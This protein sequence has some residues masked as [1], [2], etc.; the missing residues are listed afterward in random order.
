[1]LKLLFCLAICLLTTIP[2]TAMARHG[3]DGK[4]VITLRDGQPCF[5]YPRDEEIKKRVY[6]FDNLAVTKAGPQGGAGGWVIQLADYNKKI[7][8]EPDHPETCIRYG[9]LPPRAEEVTPVKPLELNTPYRAYL[10]VSTASGSE[11][12]YVTDFCLTRN[13]RGGIVLTSVNWENTVYE[14][15]CL[16]LGE[17]LKR[18]LWQRLFGK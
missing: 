5:S 17:S 7:P 13:P 3:W 16:K 2:I 4:A 15:H 6:L 12:R 1:M 11:Q 8:V 10:S 14:P 18:S 9:V